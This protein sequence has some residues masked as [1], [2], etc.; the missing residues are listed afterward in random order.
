[1][2]MQTMTDNSCVHRVAVNAFALTPTVL[3]TLIFSS[4]IFICS[5]ARFSGRQRNG[6]DLTV[7][8]RWLCRLD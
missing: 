4:P 6:H 2:T 7:V 5:C 3:A 8:H 1:M